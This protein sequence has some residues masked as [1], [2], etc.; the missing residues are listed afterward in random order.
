[1]TAIENILKNTEVTEIL[2]ELKEKGSISKKISKDGILNIDKE[3][4]FLV[5][6]RI[7]PNGKDEFTE[8]LGKT[9]S[10]YIVGSDENH[11]ICATTIGLA[12]ALSDKFKGFLILEIWM[13]SEVDGL[14]FTIYVSQKSAKETAIKL[15]EELNKVPLDNKIDNAE[16]KTTKTLAAP[17]YYSKM[18][19]IE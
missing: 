13:S 10:S 1:M 7:P 12:D 5:V 9:E 18:I 17:P 6:Y 16:V 3:V 19:N 8:Q 11:E 2:K 14:P 4:P 15:A